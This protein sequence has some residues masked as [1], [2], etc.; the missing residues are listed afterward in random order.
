MLLITVEG[1]HS[2][3]QM[4]HRSDSD[5]GSSKGGNRRLPPLL[6][7]FDVLR[8]KNR[9]LE[10]CI[11]KDNHPYIL[12]A[13]IC[14]TGGGRTSHAKGMQERTVCKANGFIFNIIRQLMLRMRSVSNY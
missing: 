13:Y 10:V 1:A 8:F 14:Y 9:F 5:E 11:C 7:D 4:S 6:G 3:E 12:Y 2:D